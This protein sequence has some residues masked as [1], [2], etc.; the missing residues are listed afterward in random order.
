MSTSPT[1][2]YWINL[3]YEQRQSRYYAEDLGNGVLLN[4]VEIPNGRFLMGSPTTETERQDNESPQHEVT[5]RSFFMG[6]YPITQ[7][8]WQAIAN[9]ELVNQELNPRPSRFKGV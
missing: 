2:K 7:A 3:H 5:L 9:L 8:Q 1:T 6:M 4:M